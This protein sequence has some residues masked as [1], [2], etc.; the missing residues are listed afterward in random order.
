MGF[1][2]LILV[3]SRWF[4]QLK[5]SE[6]L[7]FFFNKQKWLTLTTAQGLKL[8]PHVYMCMYIKVAKRNN[9]IKRI[10]IKIIDWV[11]SKNERERKKL[12]SL[13]GEKRGRNLFYNLKVACIH[14]NRSNYG[15]EILSIT[16]KLFMV[17]LNLNRLEL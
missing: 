7:S 12:L 17:D 13:E 16:L 15:G 14:W 1:L 5:P 10:N 8:P 9:K 6:F 4:F 3:S 11:F 2:G